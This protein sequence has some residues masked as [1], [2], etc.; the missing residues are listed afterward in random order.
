MILLVARLQ[1][2]CALIVEAG[3]WLKD[4]IWLINAAGSKRKW[5]GDATG[6]DLRRRE[7]IDPITHEKKDIFDKL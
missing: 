1:R 2:R 7:Q 4:W 3:S 6:T 5:I